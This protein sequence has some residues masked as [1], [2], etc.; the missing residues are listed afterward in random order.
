[1]KRVSNL[2]IVLTGGGSGGHVSPLLAIAEALLKQDSS[3]EFLYIGVPQGVEANVVPKQGYKIRFSPSVGMPNSK[4]SFQMLRFIIILLSGILTS[5]FYLIF[6]RPNVIVAS[7]GFASAPTVLA[8][9]FLRI[10]SLGLLNIPVYIHEQNAAPGRMNLLA[11]KIATAIGV[12]HSGALQYFPPEKTELVGY[13]VRSSIN[14]IER[15][16]AR[17]QLGLETNAKYIVVFGGSQG[18]RTIN[19]TIVDA[20]PFL[21]DEENI[22]IFHAVGTFKSS[23]YNAMQD[24]RSRL[25]QINSGQKNYELVD[26]SHDLPTHLAAADIAVIRA[27]AGSLQEVCTLGLPSIVIPK[28]NLPGDS[29]VANARELFKKGAIELLYEEPVLQENVLVEVASGELLAG[30]I[31][32]LIHNREK[33]HELAVNAK[34]VVRPDAALTIASTILALAKREIFKQSSP[35]TDESF[36]KGFAWSGTP[37]GIRRQ[38]EK[39][40]DIKW[41]Q[42]FIHGK[43][44]DDELE[45]LPELDYL[46]YRGAA[47]LTHSAWEVR[48]EGT[49]LIG[50]TRHSAR[51]PLLCKLLTDRTPVSRIKRALGGD[52]IQVGFIRRNIISAFALIG[53]CDEDVKEAITVAMK[54]PYYEVRAA[55]LRYLRLGY[56]QTPSNSLITLVNELVHDKNLE[57]RQEAIHTYGF[58]AEPEHFLKVCDELILDNHVL[59]R[60]ALLRGIQ[61]LLN[62][63]QLS[64]EVCEDIS[65][66]LDNFLITS[67]TVQPHFPLKEKYAS[68][69]QQ[70]QQETAQ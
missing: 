34:K 46:R 6:F 53:V 12:S 40:L 2:K 15:E 43:I 24:T 11:A 44:C 49:K 52:Y 16:V 23:S 14:S 55:C 42:A 57:V 39:F 60:D 70:L 63:H 59:L 1:M 54:D 4:I 27:G 67:T 28:A 35:F 56:I 58:F 10:I 50:L 48:N 47:L 30:I 38:V 32:E 17:R 29:Q 45:N 22:H 19:R 25:D 9:A 20:L 26:F 66:R 62:R 37:A 18:A 13:P 64:P 3:L 69:R 21:E 41:E 36:L 61:A 68:L 33:R 7:G 31:K 65:I 5:S 8:S 51:L